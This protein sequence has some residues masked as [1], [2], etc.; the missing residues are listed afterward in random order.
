MSCS[1]CELGDEGRY[2]VIYISRGAEPRNKLLYSDLRQL[3]GGRISGP[4]A[5][6]KLIDNFDADWDVSRVYTVE[7]L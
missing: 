1:S 6:T 3:E 2:L 5:M 7:P 4:L